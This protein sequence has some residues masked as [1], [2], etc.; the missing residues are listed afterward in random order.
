MTVILSLCSSTIHF[1]ESKQA[2]EGFVIPLYLRACLLISH[3]TLAI[4]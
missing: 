4:E 1:D 3:N 2:L